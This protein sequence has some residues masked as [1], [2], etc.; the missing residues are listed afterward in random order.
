MNHR[1]TTRGLIFTLINPF[2]WGAAGAA[3]ADFYKLAG[4]F[5]GFVIGATLGL[6]ATFCL[7]DALR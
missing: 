5:D 3:L 6:A 2:V 7:M 4:P 1:I